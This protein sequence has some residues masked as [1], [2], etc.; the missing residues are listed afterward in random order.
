MIV[1]TIMILLRL[2]SYSSYWCVSSLTF[3]LQYT[4]T[5]LRTGTTPPPVL[6]LTALEAQSALERSSRWVGVVI[7]GR[8]CCILVPDNAQ[9]AEVPGPCAVPLAVIHGSSRRVRD[10]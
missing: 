2:L 6:T 10:R 7:V 3:H 1:L 4:N 9:G 5:E 8:T